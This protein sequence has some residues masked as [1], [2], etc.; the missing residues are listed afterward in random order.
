MDDALAAAV[1]EQA[2]TRRFQRGQALFVE[3]D[4]AERVFLIEEGW[5]LVSCVSSSGRETVL[6]LAGPGDLLGDVS[7]VDGRPRSASATALTGL[8][9]AVAPAAA[10]T[11][12]A[13]EP[14]LA[15]Q[16]L[17]L[18]AGRLREADRKRIEFATLDTL[19]RVSTRLVEL[20]DRFGRPDGDG[21]VVE[22]P[23]SQEQLASWCAASR[24][25][26]VKALATLRSLGT[27]TTG[28]RTVVVRDL[29]ALRHHAGM[30]R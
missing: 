5:A 4:R 10:L 14:E 17:G 28:R 7:A 19:G 27:V 21:Y 29:A 24:E 8:R 1:R 2:E 3:G 22:M 6:S 11:R 9:A 26:T 20:V 16:L 25:A 12:A 30:Y 18:L 15:A 23:L 13:R